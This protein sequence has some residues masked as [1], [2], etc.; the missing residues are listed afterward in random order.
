M[1][2]SIIPLF[3]LFMGNERTVMLDKWTLLLVRDNGRVIKLIAY[4]S[5]EVDKYT[6]INIMENQ[7]EI[8]I[9][10]SEYKN[11]SYRSGIIGYINYCIERV[12]NPMPEYVLDEINKCVGLL[13]I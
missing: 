10:G 5:P 8:S 6:Y 1:D 7:V 11:N 3:N 12:Y 9:K 13:K 4:W 2:N